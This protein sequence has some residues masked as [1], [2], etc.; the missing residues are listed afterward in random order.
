MDKKFKNP[1]KNKYIAILKKPLNISSDFCGI[2]Q[3]Y[4]K[5]D[6]VRCGLYLIEISKDDIYNTL[7]IKYKPIQAQKYIFED[8]DY[9]IYEYDK[10]PTTNIVDI[11]PNKIFDYEEIFKAKGF[12]DFINKCLLYKESIEQRPDLFYIEYNKIKFYYKNGKYYRNNEEIYEY[13]LFEFF[14]KIPWEYEYDKVKLKKYNI[15]KRL[16]NLL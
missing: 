10:K 3:E 12:V 16:K 1:Y 8:V 7:Y 9:R 5:C 6:N 11:D 13:D 15:F 2:F 14:Y 4:Q